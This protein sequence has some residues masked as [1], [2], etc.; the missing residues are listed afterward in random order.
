MYLAVEGMIWLS[1]RI[2]KFHSVVVDAENKL[3]IQN[4]LDG[5]DG[6]DLLQ[7][8]QSDDDSYDDDDDDFFDAE[9]AKREA[10]DAVENATKKAGGIIEAAR[11]EADRLLAENKS[12]IDAES[13]KAMAKAK[14]EGYTMGFQQGLAEGN[15][16]AQSQID[17]AKS[18]KDETI[19]E[20]EATKARM[21]PHMVELISNILQKLALTTIRINPGVVLALVKQGLS[22]SNFSGDVTLRVSKEDFEHVV[23]KKDEL[24]EYVKGG[25]GLE[26]VIDH[27]LGAADCLIETPFGVVDSSLAMQLEEIKQDVS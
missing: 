22:Q 15:A 2:I 11:E 27:S 4:S 26:I 9:D 1:R 24:M 20:C 12:I 10:K 25:A 5:E 17:E 8:R 18:L 3:P 16:A 23:E 14:D 13:A 6:D 21:E 19:K 7:I